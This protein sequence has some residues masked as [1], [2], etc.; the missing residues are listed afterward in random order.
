MAEGRATEANVAIAG[1]ITEGVG[2]GR[3]GDA[4]VPVPTRAGTKGGL[5]LTT[6]AVPT[7]SPTR[8]Q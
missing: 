4:P 5:L 6:T 2:V 3:G 8:D 1:T 7:R